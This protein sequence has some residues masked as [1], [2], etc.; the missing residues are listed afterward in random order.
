[1]VEEARGRG[2]STPSQTAWALLALL[3]ADSPELKSATASGVEYLA[4]TITREGTWDESAYTGTGFPGYGVG[5]RVPLNDPLLSEK[6][7]QG[8]ELSRGFMIGYN[9]YRHYFPMLAL[10]R[11]RSQGH[12]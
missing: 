6:L 11:A 12:Q 2:A 7:Q 3:A 1:M 5:T 4:R 9:L 8:P 10:S